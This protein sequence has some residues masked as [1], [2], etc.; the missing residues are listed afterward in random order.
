MRL[1]FI[2]YGQGHSALQEDTYHAQPVRSPD[3]RGPVLALTLWGCPKRPEVVQA[4]PAPAGPPA[5]AP[6]R[7]PPAPAPEVQVTPPAAPAPAPPGGGP[8]DREG[9]PGH[10]DGHLLRLRQ[11][12]LKADQ[13]AA[14]Q[15]DLAALQ[16]DP[17]LKLLIEGHCDERGTAEYNLALVGSPP[18]PSRTPFRPPG[19]RPTGSRSSATARSAPS[20]SAMTRVPGSG[21]AGRTSWC[22]RCR[23]VRE[24]SDHPG[25]EGCGPA[26]PLHASRADPRLTIRREGGPGRQ[27]R[28]SPCADSG[29]QRL[30]LSH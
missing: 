30:L 27:F 18:R 8:G 7:A 9:D 5:M 19:S 11:V 2:G 6:G 28:G 17:K 12:R 21:T 14:L 29:A 20:C 25:A 1:M 15:A 22:R 3:P 13:Q 16:A 26:A 10:P 24:D 4:P 23:G